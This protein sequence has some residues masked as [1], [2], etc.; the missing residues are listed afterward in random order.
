MGVSDTI[1]CGASCQNVTTMFNDATGGEA[2]RYTGD[3]AYD[4]GITNWKTE[5]VLVFEF[6]VAS[7]PHM[8]TAKQTR[9][10]KMAKTITI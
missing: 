4:A 10:F 7:A 8:I 1:S 5:D 6:N 9:V 2:G 3:W